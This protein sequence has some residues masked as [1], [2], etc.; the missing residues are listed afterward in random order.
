MPRIGIVVSPDFQM[1]NLAVMSVFELA[2]RALKR[3]V[4]TLSRLIAGKKG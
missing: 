4:G 1:M 2:N 3:L